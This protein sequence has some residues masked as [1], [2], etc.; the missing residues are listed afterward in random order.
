MTCTCSDIDLADGTGHDPGCPLYRPDGA[1]DWP[2]VVGAESKARQWRLAQGVHDTEMRSGDKIDELLE[3][4]SRE[5]ASKVK[6]ERPLTVLAIEEIVSELKASKAEI[7]R[8][9]G[10]LEALRDKF[11]AQGKSDVAYRISEALGVCDKLKKRG[12]EARHAE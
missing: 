3:A 4:Y 6:E 12:E 1:Y 5:L 9:R 8:L 7:T 2:H 11:L 10:L